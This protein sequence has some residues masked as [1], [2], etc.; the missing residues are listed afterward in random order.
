MVAVAA[1]PDA[2]AEGAEGIAVVFAAVLLQEL[3]VVNLR[4]LELIGVVTC[5][6]GPKRRARRGS[7][8]CR[9]LSYAGHTWDC[10]TRRRA[11]LSCRPRHAGS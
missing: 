6:F 7:N 1:H 11:G 2:A 8:W 9:S 10:R 3:L 4:V 5:R